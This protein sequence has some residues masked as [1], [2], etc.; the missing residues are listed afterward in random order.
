MKKF[1]A[2]LVATVM[3]LSTV[4]AFAA[5]NM[6]KP[7]ASFSYTDN[8][9]SISGKA[10]EN[11]EV[12]VY[13]VNPGFT[14]DDIG[15]DNGAVQNFRKVTVDKEGK[16]S[17]AFKL[18]GSVEGEYKIYVKADGKEAVSTTF[19]YAGENTKET[20]VNSLFGED[21]A[22]DI[23]TVL[24]VADNVK[25]LQLAEFAP[26]VEADFDGLSIILASVLADKT[27]S[28]NDNAD[29]TELTKIIRSTAVTQLFNEG[30]ASTVVSG[31][32]I[33]YEDD[34]GVNALNE[35]GKSLYSAYKD[36]LSDSAKK[37]VISEISNKNFKST[38]DLIKA[39]AEKV[40]LKGIANPKNLG[41]GHVTK[42]LTSENCAYVGMKYNSINNAQATKI[43]AL[44]EKATIAELE[45]A[46][47]A[48]LDDPANNQIIV[49]GG[50]AAGGGGGG[51]SVVVKPTDNSYIGNTAGTIPT[52]EAP[53]GSK[54]FVDIKGYE[55]ADEAIGY[56]YKQGIISG[57]SE[58]TFAPSA[59]LTREQ[60]AKV[61]C[62]LKGIELK[63]NDKF[64]DV[65]AGAWY[66]P[67][68]GALS[69]AG[70]VSGIVEGT[71]GV[72]Y[73]ITREDLCVMIYRAFSGKI[74]AEKTKTFT[75]SASISSY[76]NEAVN[77][78]AGAGILNGFEDGSFR[79][80]ANCTRAEM[81]KIVYEIAQ[82]IK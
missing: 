60:F 45:T 67:Y 33:L 46:I 80:Q 56:L 6:D 28:G 21:S 20:I 5:E 74:K 1:I 27:A 53:K 69:D 71:Y 47:K 58:N 65:E 49:G 42:L 24:S 14:K 8:K 72:G 55:W 34:M 41:Y 51:G 32:A 16:Y 12:T 52:P 63:E 81:A 48:I 19:S 15:T 25:Y 23:K 73:N 76:A 30:K 17:Y 35:N 13:V 50:G 9:L 66:A 54:Y 4:S 57:T 70:L 44:S 2:F 3:L 7:V 18:S 11:A 39:F 43:A 82:I 40:I 37:A 78:L 29:I 31:T 64:D 61:L 68:I 26:F 75:D 77:V 59:N 62:L 36:E 22:D 38:D 10:T 79:P